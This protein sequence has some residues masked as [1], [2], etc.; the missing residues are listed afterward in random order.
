MTNRVSSFTGLLA[1]LLPF[2]ILAQAVVLS[3]S[4]VVLKQALA[5]LEAGEVAA[6]R[7]SLEAL[8]Q[9][10]NADDSAVAVLGAIYLETGEAAAAAATL[11]P[12][13]ERRSPDPAV[14]YNYGRAASVL[15]DFAVAE[16]SLEESLRLAPGSPAARELGLLRIALG[17]YFAAYLQLRPWVLT[18]PEDAQARAA[19]AFCA[20]E[21]ERPGEASL[22][23]SD[24]TQENPL[25][26][27]L[28]AKTQ[29][30]K[31]DP[32]GAIALLRPFVDDAPA[33]LE[34]ETRQV[35]AAAMLQVGNGEAVIELLAGRLND[36]PS[37]AVL[38]ARAYDL[39]GDHE[40]ALE[41]LRPFAA[42]VAEIQDLDPKD[43]ERAAQGEILFWYGELLARSGDAV[44]GLPYLERAVQLDPLNPN[45]WESLGRWRAEIGMIEEGRAAAR[46]A[47]ALMAG[48]VQRRAGMELGDDPEDV[49]TQ[50]L[51]QALR[52][53]S[54]DLLDEA[55]ELV[56]RERQLAPPEDPR[57]A[58]LEVNLLL[59]LDRLDEAQKAL[60]PLVDRFPDSADVHYQN[61]VLEVAK[62]NLEAAEASFRKTLEL[63][64]G[65]LAA[66][67]DFAVLLLRNDR[68]D[69]AREMLENVLTLRPDDE[70]ARRNLQAIQ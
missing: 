11:K 5:D 22:L 4:E 67:N 47:E 16:R 68:P 45:K 23:L 55:L 53:A 26:K 29:L 57:P 18:H 13:A 34:I 10:G 6:A 28:W 30:M 62:N 19:A 27:L 32:W 52:L 21:L 46:K 14:L 50:H 20:V 7:A 31:Q 61:A 38:S 49:T 70:V 37:L 9:S 58:L 35:L 41:A 12:I 17:D 39:V 65:H 51:E 69:E 54:A 64:P 24:L 33:D 44:S 40:A 25:V 2:G 36:N 8:Q 59:R 3:Q 60:E 1:L 43:S 66:M 63:S 48:T 15:G 56:R 42:S